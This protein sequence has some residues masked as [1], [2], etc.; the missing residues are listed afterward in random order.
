MVDESFIKLFKSLF[1]A[2]E[3]VFAIAWQRA[4]RVSYTPAYM[5]DPYH[6][7]VYKQNGGTF[8][9]YPHKSYLPLD[10]I[11][12]NKHLQGEF[13]IGVYPLLQDNTSFFLVADF[14]K[15]NW[16]KQAV[17]FIDICSVKGIPAYLE[18][19]RSGNGGHVWIFFDRAFAAYKSRKIFLDLL[20][21]AGGVSIFEK[22][23]SFDRLFP[24]QDYLSKKGFGNLIALPFFKPTLEKGNS[25]FID[26]VTFK[27][28]ENQFEFLQQIKRAKV[29]LLEKLFTCSDI[30]NVQ[31]ST[32][33]TIYL[34]KEIRINKQAIPRALIDF[35]KQELTFYNS[36]YF[37]KKNAGKATYNTPMYYQS[38]QE[39]GE[40]VILPRGFIG[41][42]L[43]FCKGALIDFDFI[44]QRELKQTIP[45]VFNAT[46]L[47]HQ[48]KIV[49]IIDKK[50]FGVIVAPPGS[51]KTI[52]GLKIIAHH[53]QPALIVVHRK[54]LL[55]QWQERIQAFLGISKK[56][57]GIIGQGKST[58][59]K[60]VTIATIQSLPK[61]L[62]ELHNKF[63][64]ILVDEC[65][66]IPAKTFGETIQGLN[67]YY[68]YG[69]TA[70]AFR[71]G[72]DTKLIFS[73]LGDK[74]LEIAEHEI[75]KF[76]KAHI[77]IRNTQLD[78]AF[79]SKT[80]DFQT[81]SK[82]L[83]HDSSRNKLIVQDVITEV[84][85]QRKVAI[86]T[87]RIEH[88]DVL[89]L[90]LKHVGEVVTLSGQDSQS[91][92]KAKLQILGKGNFQILITTGQYFG[93]GADFSMLSS[94][95]LVYPFAFKGKLIQ[96]I[97]RVQRSELT[98]IIYD[99]RDIKIQ[100]LDRLFLKRNAY[101]GKIR[102]QTSLFDEPFDI[103]PVNKDITIDKKVK[104]PIDDLDFRYAH[105][106]FSYK[107]KGYEQPFYFEIENEQIR[108]EFQVLKP[109]FSKVLKSKGVEVEIYIEMQNFKVVSLLATS[110]DLESIN[111]QVIDSVKFSYLDKALVKQDLGLSSRKGL[112]GFNQ[113]LKEGG[114]YQTQEQFIKEL[115]NNA[116]Y[117][118]S[119]HIGYLASNHLYQLLKIKFV[120]QPFSFVF[121]LEGE[122]QYHLVLETLDTK[123]ATYIWHMNKQGFEV[124]QALEQLEKDLLLIRENGRQAYVDQ[125]LENFT[126]I[127][128]DYSNKQK[129]FSL[130]KDMLEQWLY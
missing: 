18:R 100:Y 123:E 3:D 99:Y 32:R 79:D 72:S 26:P 116:C 63:G 113:I 27:A 5:Y 103:E 54:L 127:V 12:L 106:G 89:Y 60:Q 61:K 1:Q 112:L 22:S 37:A 49:E 52:M 85:K 105:I 77:I 128:H 88:I 39:L 38:I 56:E 9:D 25:C 107:E 51:G 78:I 6:F 130:W 124:E 101:Y 64:L 125:G 47:E 16:Q 71:K 122:N 34:A 69:L 33:L 111:K 11:Q 81:L 82:I 121:L 115:H 20:K 67:T 86:I 90:M 96:Y 29:D 62:V 129:G 31:S 74:L 15:Q 4:G 117:E 57:I 104:I 114:I 83:V 21:Q 118:H 109:Y 80:D 110:E 35:I 58:I 30:V 45:F 55:E 28:F 48:K 120:L 41:K 59:G 119:L 70:T 40:Q 98:P 75:Q 92:K 102:K 19:S 126:R 2:R 84:N 65:H 17:D 87:E 97:G 76:K 73:F 46:L 66:H 42:L 10:E 8:Q 93:E 23:S 13:Q 53:K 7:R 43:R 108:P 94:L 91:N 14:D 36:E 50:N 68:L 24:N 44:D 95:F